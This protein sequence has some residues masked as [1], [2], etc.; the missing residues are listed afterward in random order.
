MNADGDEKTGVERAR[1]FLILA[2]VVV[3]VGFGVWRLGWFVIERDRTRWK[4]AALVRLQT[5]STTNELIRSEVEELRT[6]S[7]TNE[8]EWVH[9]HVL[10]M[11]NGQFIVYEYRHGRNGYFPPHLFL[12]RT[13]DGQWLYS[14]YHF[15]NGVGMVRWDSPGSVAEFCK[16]YFVRT[17]DGKSDECL[18]LTW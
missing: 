10:M 9:D 1:R 17:F 14:S 12:G 4:D 2:G 5:L 13:S 16:K 8:L 11:T 3:V 7:K 6:P 18:K 15:C